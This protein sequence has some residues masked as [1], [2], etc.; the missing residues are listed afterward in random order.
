MYY[1]N[2]HF[3]VSF[4]LFNI[5]YCILTVFLFKKTLY[6]DYE[7]LMVPFAFLSTLLEA[8]IAGVLLNA[9]HI[10]NEHKISA[11]SSYFFGS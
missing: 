10:V 3:F 9:D 2:T 5:L 8:G 1:L 6:T 4:F 11:L 7:F